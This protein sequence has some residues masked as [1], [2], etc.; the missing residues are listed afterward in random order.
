MPLAVCTR[1]Y[2][3][4]FSGHASIRRVLMRAISGFGLLLYFLATA[5]IAGPLDLGSFPVSGSGTFACDVLD[6]TAGFSVFFSGSN[7]NYSITAG[8]PGLGGSST[9]NLQFT[10]V[11]ATLGEN[12]VLADT[13]PPSMNL[14]EPFNASFSQTG[15][16][17]MVSGPAM[18]QLGN[19]TGFLDIYDQASAQPGNPA[20]LIAT[21]T[22]AGY[23]TVDSVQT[24]EPFF[25][26]WNGTYAI[27][28]VPEPGSTAMFLIA[29]LWP[30]AA[31]AVYSARRRI[32]SRSGKRASESS[33]SSQ[34]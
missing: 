31:G 17:I 34:S 23:V 30:A 10:C 6:A 7:A 24:M 15:S 18:F 1:G 20:N 33:P 29:A 9:K 22:L 11:G 19:G 21:A 25:P 14:F 26:A 28:P 16:N 5:A 2:R 32:R 8:S 4:R 12:V 27:T 3:P 13:N